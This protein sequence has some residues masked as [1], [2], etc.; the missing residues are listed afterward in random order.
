MLI[1]LIA[2]VAENGVIGQ[3][4]DLV[5]RLPDDFRYFKQTTSHHPILMGRKTFESL[6]KPLLNR[7]NV[8]ITRNPDY[9]PDGVV[10]VDSLEKA[11][12]EARKT[13]I[14][15]AFV[16][17]GAEI[18]R[19]AIDSAD[20]LYL[21]EVK[22]SFEGDATFPDFDK[23]HW[24]EISRRHHATDERHAVA[25]DFVVWERKP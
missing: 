7:L 24:Q 22:A 12:D 10:V 4:N 1:S 25:F 14:D 8:V 6:G 11:M 20:R 19:Q 2:A 16:I 3:D 21:T 13:G 15:E 9:R 18:Y 5:W 17:G 23:S